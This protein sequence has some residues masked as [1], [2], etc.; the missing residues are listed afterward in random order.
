ML[1]GTAERVKSL[2]WSKSLETVR[3]DEIMKEAQ[4]KAKQA[5]LWRRMLGLADVSLSEEDMEDVDRRARDRLGMAHPEAAEKEVVAKAAAAEEMVV[6]AA[7]KA[8]TVE[9]IVPEAV[10]AVKTS[11]AAN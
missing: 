1:Y 3:G 2:P 6:D 5:P 10:E 8:G 11:D 9:E 4:Q 7:A